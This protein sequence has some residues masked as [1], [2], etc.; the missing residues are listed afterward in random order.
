MELV[1][2][3]PDEVTGLSRIV[4]RIDP[5]DCQ[6]LWLRWIN[7]R[8]IL[9]TSLWLKPST[10]WFVLLCLFIFMITGSSFMKLWQ[11]IVVR[12]MI[13]FWTK[14]VQNSHTVPQNV[15]KIVQ[16]AR[17]C[18][19]VFISNRVMTSLGNS[20]LLYWSVFARNRDTA[21][22][23][24]G[25]GDLQTLICVLVARPRQCLTLSNPVPWQN[26]MAA[27]LGYTLRTKTL[28]PGWPIMV[29]DTHT[30]RR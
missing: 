24:E 27:Y 8:F 10:Q 30:R 11:L 15:I 7:L 23:A 28:F 6:R 19:K 1:Y 18:S 9:F 29:H 16:S 5:H 17:I 22:P 12:S 13:K 2:Q 3:T 25:N 14:S 20:G 4:Y 26:W 21:V